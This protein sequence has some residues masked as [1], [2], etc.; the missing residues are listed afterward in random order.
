MSRWM[1]VGLI[2]LGLSVVPV[3]SALAD[4][5][6]PDKAAAQKKVRRG[7]H[8]KQFP[9]KGADFL[10]KMDARSAKAKERL[11]HVLDRKKVDA[12]KRKAVL[13]DFDA[14]RAKVR[15]AAEVAAKDGTVSIEEAK[16]VRGV[17][18]EARKAMKEKHGISGKHG[19][20]HK[21][22]KGKGGKGKK[23]TPA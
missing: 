1:K 3:S 14:G 23:G 18:K 5:G 19:K 10:Q 21:D 16:T 6:A 20:R 9:M 8:A 17:A 7:D 22:G 2:A 15:A 13:A 4:S 12:D 11:V